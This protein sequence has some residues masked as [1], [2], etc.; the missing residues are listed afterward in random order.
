MN[1]DIHRISIQISGSEESVVSFNEQEIEEAGQSYPTGIII[2]IEELLTTL[3]K[4]RNSHDKL[5]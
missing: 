4:R 2:P 3:F 1:K 5:L